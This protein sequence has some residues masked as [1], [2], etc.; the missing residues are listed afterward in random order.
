MEDVA[1]DYLEGLFDRSLIQ[2]ATKRLDGGVKT[3][4]IHNLLQDLCISESIEGKFIE[5]RSDVYFS[6]MSKSRR[7]SIHYFNYPYISSSPCE[8][9][10]SRSIAL[11]I[12][13]QHFFFHLI[14]LPLSQYIHNYQ[15]LYIIFGLISS[16]LLLLFLIQYFPIG[17]CFVLYFFFDVLGL[18][19][20]VSLVLLH[21]MR[22]LLF[23]EFK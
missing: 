18:R 17:I 3:C 16:L 22:T 7:I 21:F 2:V 9:S 8:P 1:E 11:N 14:L 10:N 6:P 19:M 23:I 13:F 12:H 5:V 15:F 4:R 20:S